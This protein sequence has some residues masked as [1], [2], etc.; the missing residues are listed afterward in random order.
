LPGEDDHRGRSALLKRAV[1]VVAIGVLLGLVVG[2]RFT[3]PTGDGADDLL[4]DAALKTAKVEKPKDASARPTDAKDATT[5]APA[6]AAVAPQ[7]PASPPVAEAAK[8]AAP[9][10]APRDAKAGDERSDAN[11]S[12]GKPDRAERAARAARRRSAEGERDRDA[13]AAAKPSAA[14]APKPPPDPQ[15]SLPASP[16]APVAKPPRPIPPP[17]GSAA[18]APSALPPGVVPPSTSPQ[19]VA[20]TPPPPPSPRQVEL[21]PPPDDA[22]DLALLFIQWSA[23]PTKRVASLRQNGGGA[24]YIVREGDIVQGLRVAAIRPSGIEIQWRGQSFLLPAARY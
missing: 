17:T 19:L 23:D 21:P 1:A 5:P 24:I 8:T 18:I 14:V 6:P 3:G 20:S 2:R 16:M 9:P 10:T 22:P 12:D 11:A 13:A 15:Q 4:S 7:P